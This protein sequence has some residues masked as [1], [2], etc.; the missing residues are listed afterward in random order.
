MG[1]QVKPAGD[2]AGDPS[3]PDF[4][5]PRFQSEEPEANILRFLTDLSEAWQDLGPTTH[6]DDVALGALRQ[7]RGIQID[8]LPPRAKARLT[9]HGTRWQAYLRGTTEAD[10]VKTRGAVLHFIWELLRESKS[11]PV[12]PAP[13]GV[14]AADDD[15]EGNPPPTLEFPPGAVKFGGAE[16]PLTGKPWEV[17]RFIHDSRDR[18][19][20]LD[21]IRK[22][23][24]GDT[25]VDEQTVRTHVSRARKALR[26]LFKG[27]KFD[28]IKCVNR[29]TGKTAFHVQM[30]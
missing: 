26:K 1:E 28:P 12:E 11:K 16:V 6:A 30:P 5:D 18:R 3:E 10:A 20:T 29:G 15:V 7:A 17:L 19:A 9:I 23:V 14:P 27:K 22:A 2:P 8:G 4:Q 21:E 13:G 25:V 24:W